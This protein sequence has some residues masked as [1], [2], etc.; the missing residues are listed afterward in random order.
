MTSYELYINGA[1]CDMAPDT[2]ISLV[3]QNGIFTSL[4]AIQSNRSYHIDLPMTSR[5]V[6]IFQFANM[7]DVDSDMPYIKVSAALYKGGVPIFEKGFAVITS[8]TDVISVTLTWGNVENFDPLFDSPMSD[9]ADTLYDMGIGSIPWN[10]DSKVLTVA[11]SGAGMGF[12][13]IDY[14]MG[15]SKPQYVHPA[16]RVDRILE[17]IEKYHGIKIEGMPLRG[18]WEYSHVVPCLSQNGDNRINPGFTSNDIIYGGYGG[19]SLTGKDRAGILEKNLLNQYVSV[20]VRDVNYV[21]IKLADDILGSSFKVEFNAP[22]TTGNPDRDVSFII[23]GDGNELYK[24]TV[25]IKGTDTSALFIN[26]NQNFDVG[27]INRLVFSVHQYPEVGSFKRLVGTLSIS[28]DFKNNKLIY[29]DI[30]P[31]GVN[32]PDMTHGDF[33]QALMSLTGT[34]AYVDNT[35]PNTI[36]LISPDDILRTMNEAVFIDWSRKVLLNDKRMVSMPDASEFIVG[37]YAQKNILDYDNDD[38]VTAKTEGVITIDNVNLDKETELTDLEFSASENVDYGDGRIARIPIYTKE[39]NAKE[40]DPA[41]YSELS[42]RILE[43]ITVEKDDVE[44]AAAFFPSTLHF[45]GRDGIVASYYN[46]LQKIL[47]RLRIITIRAKLSVLDLYNLDYKMPIYLAQF[48]CYYAIYSITTG[49]GDVCECLLIQLPHTSI[50]KPSE[51]PFILRTE[52]DW[53]GMTYWNGSCGADYYYVDYEKVR[54]K[55]TYSDGTVRYSDY[56]NGESRSRRIDGQCGWVRAWRA[57]SDWYRTG[58]TCNAAGVNG[59]YDCDGT[60]SVTYWN[61]GQHQSYCYP[62]MSGS[63]GT[64]TIWRVGP[65]ATR[66]QVDGQCGYTPKAYQLEVSD[67]SWNIVSMQDRTETSS[68][69]QP[70]GLLVMTTSCQYVGYQPIPVFAMSGIRLVAPDGTTSPIK[71][72][73]L[74]F[75]RRDGLVM[76]CSVSTTQSSSDEVRISFR[77]SGDTTLQ[78]FY[79]GKITITHETGAA[80]KLVISVSF[81]S[82]RTESGG[83]NLRPTLEEVDALTADT[84]ADT[85]EEPEA[86]AET[87]AIDMRAL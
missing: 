28:G 73:T 37:D 12:F 29:P 39:A 74:S 79:D 61:E 82:D 27:N 41:D 16:V 40:E 42:P 86:A 87:A 81:H 60:Y 68:L 26:I 3:Y 72:R 36:K 9:L 38:D 54:D 48:G 77:S 63:T 52:V 14:G 43:R 71:A 51:W 53:D 75:E 23:Y 11:E 83:G 2:Q 67:T 56:R 10:E 13:T 7:P 47:R 32:L 30:Y 34:F 80:I 15:L 49:E 85:T 46:G 20:N 59:A 84:D 65:E 44:F 70:D 22:Q 25:Q 19:L 17:A 76:N 62:D 1:L 58:G 55:Y 45:G 21:N 24:Q 35:Q 8:I 33:L 78:S 50:V 4:D 5:N 57:T 64:R 31:I 69:R 18:D 6:G 66:E